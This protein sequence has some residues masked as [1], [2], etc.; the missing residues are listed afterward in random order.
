[1]PDQRAYQKLRNKY[2]AGGVFVSLYDKVSPRMY[3]HA[4]THTHTH[5]HTCM[6]VRMHTIM[7]SYVHS[8]I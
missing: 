8:Y 2:G 3:T 7:H 4:H 5:T 6:H 1:M